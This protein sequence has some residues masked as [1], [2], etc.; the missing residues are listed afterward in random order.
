MMKKLFN[1]LKWETEKQ[2]KLMPGWLPIH[3]F[4]KMAKFEV[5]DR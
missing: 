2:I 1:K 3:T 5:N 4:Y